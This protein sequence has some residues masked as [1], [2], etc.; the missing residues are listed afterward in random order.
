MDKTKLTIG[1]YAVLIAGLSFSCGGESTGG[2]WTE[3]DSAEDR[4]LIIQP[5]QIHELNEDADAAENS[6]FA[7]ENSVKATLAASGDFNW[8]DFRN[9]LAAQE[10]AI[11]EGYY[12]EEDEVATSWQK[13]NDQYNYRTVYHYHAGELSLQTY[14]KDNSPSSNA[15]DSAN[16]KGKLLTKE[17]SNDPAFRDLWNQMEEKAKSLFK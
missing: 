14:Y 10:E 11:G 17:D 7:A 12:Q 16:E 6:D 4:L 15:D 1:F 5:E 3:I 8:E 2:N 13:L 9:Q